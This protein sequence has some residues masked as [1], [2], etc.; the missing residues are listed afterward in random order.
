MSSSSAPAVNAGYPWLAAARLHGGVTRRHSSAVK[1]RG[2][3]TAQEHGSKV[4]PAG[5]GF[6][7]LRLWINRMTNGAD[8]RSI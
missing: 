7:A 4:E 1:R 8:N 3:T 5:H 2:V 6:V